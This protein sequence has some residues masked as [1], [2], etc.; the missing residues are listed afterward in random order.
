MSQKCNYCHIQ[1]RKQFPDRVIISGV[2]L[3]RYNQRSRDPFSK[4]NRF[5]NSIFLS[6]VLCWCVITD[7]V[8]VPDS[9]TEISFLATNILLTRGA[10]LYFQTG[11]W[12]IFLDRQKLHVVV[13][14]TLD[15]ARYGI[16]AIS[17]TRV[18]GLASRGDLQ[19]LQCCNFWLTDRMT[20]GR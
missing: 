2:S 3:D 10:H 20:D 7:P 15:Q 9:V 14:L 5:Q 17:P 19:L 1:E 8:Q 16:Y 18:N 11:L 4:A 12:R 13:S 6:L